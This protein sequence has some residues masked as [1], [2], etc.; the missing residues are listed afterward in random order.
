MDGKT[1]FCGTSDEDE[2]TRKY[3]S[4]Y[5]KTIKGGF[6]YLTES[7]KIETFEL[8][9]KQVCFLY[10]LLCMRKVAKLMFIR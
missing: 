3:T 8:N 4:E 10:H 6:K 1:S 9:N 5:I 2:I 7:F